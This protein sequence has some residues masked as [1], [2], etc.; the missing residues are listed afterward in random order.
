[1]GAEHTVSIDVMSGSYTICRLDAGD[2]LPSW[3]TPAPFF[4]VTRTAAEL[5][6]VCETRAVPAGVRAEHGWRVLAVRGPLDFTLT[7]IVAALSAV[8]AAEAISIFVVSTFDTDYLLVRASATERAIAAL[9]DAGH[10]VA[11]T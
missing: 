5:S 2:A 7:G 8:L 4:S 9:R 3:A 6:V 11:G 1:M 10:I